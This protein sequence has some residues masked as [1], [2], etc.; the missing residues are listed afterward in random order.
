MVWVVGLLV[1][2]VVFIIGIMCKTIS[3]IEQIEA[4][5]KES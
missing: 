3:H 1:M 2:T 5:I 4:T